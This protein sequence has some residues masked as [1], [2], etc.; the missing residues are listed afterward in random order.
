MQVVSIRP[1]A[2][3]EEVSSGRT[4][5]LSSFPS[6]QI[7][8]GK[9]SCTVLRSTK[10]R[11]KQQVFCIQS[12]ECLPPSVK[13]RIKI[14][15]TRLAWFKGSISSVSPIFRGWFIIT[16][17]TRNRNPIVALQSVPTFNYCLLHTM[18]NESQQLI[19]NIRSI[20]PPVTFL[21]YSISFWLLLWLSILKAK[22][23]PHYP[24]IPSF[25]LF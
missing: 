1:G 20:E 19:A 14:P 3:W 11:L 21:K 6:P 10:Y 2:G 12:I 8:C 9:I 16:V 15:W 22:I 18:L 7:P 23:Y 25:H 17:D 24:F 4:W 5:S 13:P